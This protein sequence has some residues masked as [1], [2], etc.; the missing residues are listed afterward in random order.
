MLTPA[1][2]ADTCMADSGLSHALIPCL[3]DDS[4]DG[5]LAGILVWPHPFTTLRGSQQ[6]HHPSRLPLPSD[7]EDLLGVTPQLRTCVC[8][9][10]CTCVYM[11]VCVCVCVCVQLLCSYPDITKFELDHRS[12]P[13][14]IVSQMSLLFKVHLS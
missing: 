9:C 1:L 12:I 6:P 5:P 3:L 10:V 14:R 11:Y 2:V 7:R 8:V 4:Y 13:L